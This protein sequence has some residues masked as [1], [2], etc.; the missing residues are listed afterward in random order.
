MF[1]GKAGCRFVDETD[2][3]QIIVQMNLDST[4]ANGLVKF[5]PAGLNFINVLRTA[6]TLVDP[7]SVKRY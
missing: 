2:W 7:K 5:T 4:Y 6:F 3:A 1:T